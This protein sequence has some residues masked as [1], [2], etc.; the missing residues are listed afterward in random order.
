MSW[1]ERAVKIVS[2]NK[3]NISKELFVKC[4]EGLKRINDYYDEI[5]SIQRKYTCDG[6]LYA[7]PDCSEIVLMLLHN[8]CGSADNGEFINNFIFDMDYGQTDNVIVF[9]KKK[10][11]LSSAENLYDF[12]VEVN[13]SSQ[14]NIV[15]L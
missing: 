6:Y 1:I 10:Y 5:N 9:N 8:A 11:V 14:N 13:N 15:K 7:V 3:L 2:N 12:L 4:I